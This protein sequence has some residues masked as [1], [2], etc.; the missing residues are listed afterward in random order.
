MLRRLINRRGQSTA[1]YA[2]LIGLVIASV[3]AMQTYVKR[4]LQG[5]VRDAVDH[6]GVVDSEGEGTEFSFTGRL[7]EPTYI[8]SKFTTERADS[9]KTNVELGGKVIRDIK[10][11]VTSRI[12]T[13]TI[14]YDKEE[15]K[16]EEAGE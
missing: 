11:K 8:E 14:L 13:Q 9:V 4:G 12:G 10:E 6:V 15:D 16:A 1:E 2:I 5:R 3:I 7:F